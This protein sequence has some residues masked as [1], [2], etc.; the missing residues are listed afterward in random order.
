MKVKKIKV[1]NVKAI[2][3]QELDLNGATVIVMGGNNKGKSTLLRALKDR[4]LKIKPDE[5][6]KKGETDGLYVMEFTSGDRIEWEVTTKTKAGEKLTLISKDGTKTSAIT[7]IIK[8]FGPSDFDIDKFFYMQPAQ[9]RKAL[10]K[11]LGVDLSVIDEKYAKAV[12]ERRD[13]NRDV[14]RIEAMYA[15]KYT[16]DT[17][18]KVPLPVDHLEK[19][20]L[21]VELVQERYDSAVEEETRL[22]AQLAQLKAQMDRINTRLGEIDEFL[23]EPANKPKSVE[24]IESIKRQIELTKDTNLKIQ[25]NNK[26]SEQLIELEKLREAAHHKEMAVQDITAKRDALIKASKLPAGFSFGDEGILYNGL[27]LTR[28][29]L[30]SS[31]IY[32]AALK[33]ASLNLGNV[34]MLHFDASML[35]NKSLMEVRDWAESQDLQLGIEIVERDGSDIRYE[36]IE[37]DWVN[38]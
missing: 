18:P 6:V 21:S 9:Q 16:D 7:D 4:L 28:E 35:D 24:E 37:D 19:Q 36:I 14:E 2:A 10:E 22:E 11:L 15:G 5:I 27:P 30:S 32:I 17:L 29:Q 3:D 13:A 26:M 12:Q 20:L 31:A 33:L 38:S 34:R 8:W 25:E 1:H 23:T